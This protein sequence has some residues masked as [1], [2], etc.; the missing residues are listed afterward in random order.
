M[1]E[2]H[3]RA[4]TL[5]AVTLAVAL[6]GCT[7]GDDSSDDANNDDNAA[8]TGDNVAD[9]PAR[10]GSFDANGNFRPGVIAASRTTLTS[11]QSSDLT[12]RL[13][14]GD[15]G[16]SAQA[17]S[18]FF[19][20]PCTQAGDADITP[21]VVDSI[22]GDISATYT[23]RGCNSPDTVTARTSIDGRSLSADVTLMPATTQ[24]AALAFVSSSNPQI[25]I[26]G[27]GVLPPQS[28]I[29][30]VI[31]DDN[32]MPVP[33]QAVNFTLDTTVG[34]LSLS[35]ATARTN[36]SGNVT[37]TVTS[38][39]QATT[40]QVGARTIG[41]SGRT[42]AGQSRTLAVT[43]GLADQDSF[44]VS[45]ER[46]NIEGLD[47]DGES[48]PVI[49]RAAD[50]FN[51]PVPD[52]TT[53][54]FTTEGGA[55][56]GSCQTVDGACSVNFVSQNPRPA[57]G[58]VTVLATAAGEESFVDSNP[59]NGRFDPGE[60][61][62]DLPEAYLDAD[63]DGERDPDERYIDFND[64]G[65][66][67]MGSGTYSGL[68][69]NAGDRCAQRDTI[70]AR[71]DIVIV[72]SG[73]SLFIDVPSR[74]TLAENATTVSVLVRDANGQKPPAGTTIEA[75]TTL[76]TI[77]GPS[78]FT[79]PTTNSEGGSVFRV[80]IEPEDSSG[81]GILRITATSPSGV[82]SRATTDVA[83]NAPE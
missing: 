1:I 16:N 62:E 17:T 77:E 19:S 79:V 28:Q 21:Q 25:G 45:A 48:T 30:F 61:F 42:V 13:R 80:R 54:N 39:T 82:I 20:S 15:E 56:P 2:A 73:S 12:L 33:N 4:R 11:G 43:T 18:V 65:R 14:D 8:G 26:Q 23:P 55:I 22:D 9:T 59:S 81:T 71:G 34:G 5:L 63:N 32:G 60:Q 6:F 64:N 57:D 35:P 27:T 58:R 38:G 10:L 74:V 7:S 68:L 51:N 52:G 72:L 66:Y 31:T 36:S 67:D 50:R 49:V 70:A 78:S 24:A 44:S 3:C 46:L 47:R 40:V 69:C 76:G 37:T 75:E 41:A 29:T 83:E 53:I